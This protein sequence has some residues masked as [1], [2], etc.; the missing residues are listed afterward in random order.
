M[1]TFTCMAFT[2]SFYFS[3][4]VPRNRF[5]KQKTN[6]VG[7]MTTNKGYENSPTQMKC[8]FKNEL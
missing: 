1:C 4:L 3:G 8:V 5:N 6:N 2:N 7:T